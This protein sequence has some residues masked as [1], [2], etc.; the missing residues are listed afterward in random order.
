MVYEIVSEYLLI[1][2][3]DIL[4]SYLFIFIGCILYIAG[5]VEMSND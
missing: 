5:F 4:A 3:E 2:G 1:Y